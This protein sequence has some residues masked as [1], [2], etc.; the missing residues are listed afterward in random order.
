MS[1]IKPRILPKPIVWSRLNA[2]KNRRHTRR[3]MQHQQ[4]PVQ[5]QREPASGHPASPKT[6]PKGAPAILLDHRRF[7]LDR[8]P[9]GYPRRPSCIH[10]RTWPADVPAPRAGLPGEHA[11]PQLEPSSRHLAS[12]VPTKGRLAIWWSVSHL[13]F[14]NCNAIRR[15]VKQKAFPCG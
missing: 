7:T 1:V 4:S 13:N 3:A 9:G 15:L 12:G 8:I 10:T 6:Q 2:E 11:R 5:Q 14:S